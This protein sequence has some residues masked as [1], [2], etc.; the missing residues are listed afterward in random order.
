MVQ[1]PAT[2]SS[3]AVRR[4]RSTQA[5][6]G[7]GTRTLIRSEVDAAFRRQGPQEEVV[8]VGY[9]GVPPENR[10]PKKKKKH[11]KCVRK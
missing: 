7:H 3:P 4:L 5:K 11:V 10:D 2:P 6:A 8:S 1:W 9:L